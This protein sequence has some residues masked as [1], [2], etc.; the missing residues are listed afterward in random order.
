[1]LGSKITILYLK[2]GRGLNNGQQ[3]LYCLKHNHFFR[4]LHNIKKL[5]MLLLDILKNKDVIENN[6]IR[7]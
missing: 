3:T 2:T 7:V 5:Q 1:M 4:L 6:K